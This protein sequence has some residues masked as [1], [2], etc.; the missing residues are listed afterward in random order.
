MLVHT[1][2][3]GGQQINVGEEVHFLATSPLAKVDTVKYGH[4]APTPMTDDR[5]HSEPRYRDAD[6][7]QHRYV[8]QRQSASEIAAAC[9]V[10]ESTV[11]RWLDHH[12][13]ERASPYKEEQWLRTQY[14]DRGRR[15]QDI[16]D[17]CDVAVSTICHWLGRHGITDGKSYERTTCA[18]CG[19]PFRYAPSIRAGT[20]CS[21]ACA[22]EQRK[23]QVTVECPGCGN[24]FERRESLDTEY[25]SMACWGED[26]RVEGE[27]YRGIWNRQREKALKRDGYEC[28]ECGISDTEHRARFGIGLDVHH[29]VPV[30]LFAKWNCPISD[31]H[32][33]S[34]LVTYCRTHHPDGNGTTVEP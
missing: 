29:R 22:N 3:F 9:G 5:D 2:R 6:F 15:Q 14:V 24:T 30:R 23:R 8:D 10:T 34:N 7:L 17:D 26:I 13:V 16:A 32:S 19:E 20:Y 4:S 21:N 1:C 18:T 27:F 12:D 33:V 28:V 11:S 31:A 25:C